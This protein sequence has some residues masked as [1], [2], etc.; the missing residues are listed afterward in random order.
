MEFFIC[1]DILS[2][3]ISSQKSPYGRAIW[4]LF[5][6]SP[7]IVNI[8][9]CVASCNLVAKKNGL[10]WECM[11]NDDFTVLV[12]GGGR[13]HWVSL[14]TAWLWHVKCLRKWS[15]KSTSNVVLSL[16]IPPWKLFWWFRRPQLWA[17]G[18]WQ[19]HPNNAPAHASC[20]MQN[21]LAKHQ[22]TQVTQPPTVHIWCPVADFWLFPKLKS[23]LKGKRFQSLSEIQENTT[24]QL[25]V[26]GRT[27]WV[28]KVPTLKGTEASLSYVQCFLYLLQT[29]SLFFILH[30][31]ITSGQTSYFKVTEDIV[32]LLIFH[33][34]FVV[35]CYMLTTELPFLK[36]EIDMFFH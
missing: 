13:H 7:A 17:T 12:S 2:L 30:G 5:G 1:L 33:F 3:S 29:M 8:T 22:I 6:K 16:N 36:S 14:C 18:D 31:W 15:N 25:M 19:L 21:F 35:V 10:E 20:L 11:N 23:P 9:V 26:I 4:G 34:H 28:P 27:V 24:G 32:T